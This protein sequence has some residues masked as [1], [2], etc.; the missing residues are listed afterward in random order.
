MMM[1]VNKQN[2]KMKGMCFWKSLDNVDLD[3]TFLELL[4]HKTG[5]IQAEMG[6]RD[7]DRSPTNC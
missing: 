2:T 6:A 3:K 1:S 7:S 5:G 4:S